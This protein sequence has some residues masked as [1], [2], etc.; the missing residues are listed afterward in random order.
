MLAQGNETGT[1]GS[2]SGTVAGTGDGKY[3]TLVKV[4]GGF[5]YNELATMRNLITT[6]CGD[7]GTSTNTNTKHN[8]ATPS[9]ISTWRPKRDDIPHLWIPP[10]HSFVIQIKCAE[11][12]PSSSFSSGY[13][14]RFPRFVCLRPDK[15]VDDIMS[16]SDIQTIVDAPRQ[17]SHTTGSSTMGSNMGAGGVLYVNDTDFHHT[18]TYNSYGNNND[19]GDVM[20]MMANN[21]GNTTNTGHGSG[22]GIISERVDMLRRKRTKKTVRKTPKPV[23]FCVLESTDFNYNYAC[24]DTSGGSGRDKDKGCVYSRNQVSIS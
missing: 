11:I 18:N 3:H 9:Y 21:T 5:D 22:G 7:T 12:T 10:S 24:V 6:A 23:V 14:C 8:T 15:G 4:G 2:G 20:D 17:L 13:T 1:G 19:N 16:L